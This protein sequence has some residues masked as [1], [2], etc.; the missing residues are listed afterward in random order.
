M[1]G[2]S[3]GTGCRAAR[4]TR[5]RSSSARPCGTRRVP[6]ARRRTGGRPCRSRSSASR[7][8]C[9]SPD[10]S[11]LHQYSCRLRLQNHVRPVVSVLLQRLAVHPREHQHLPGAGFLHDRRD[12]PVGVV[13]NRIELVGGEGNRRDRRATWRHDGSGAPLDGPSLDSARW[14]ILF[15]RSRHDGPSCSPST[16][17][18]ASTTGTGCATAT[19]PRYSRIS[20][21]R[22]RTREAVLAPIAAAD[23]SRSSRRSRA[24]SR[25]PTSRRRFRTGRGSTTRARSRA[26]STRMHCRRPHEPHDEERDAET[27]A[28]RRERRGG[29]SR[30][31]L[32][33]RSSRSRP[34][35]GLLAYAVDR[36]RRR[37][38]PVALP[39]PPEWRIDLAD[40]I[41]DVT[42][43]F[44]WADDARTCFYVRPDDAMRP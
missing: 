28:A 12:E 43:G 15:R 1:P 8:Y 26:G 18:I 39:R 4:R 42:Y 41:E 13:R 27:R 21:P 20:K 23:A 31:L 37:A 35:T 32:A 9:R 44:A 36:D 34:T 29:G 10:V 7:T 24:A 3:T 22:T 25:R 30:L 40:E 11:P 33:R 38:L 5:G 6:L 14:S 19:T 2:R 16:A 17:T